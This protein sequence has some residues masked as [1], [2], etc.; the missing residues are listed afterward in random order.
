[1]ENFNATADN[2]FLVPFPCDGI[3]LCVPGKQHHQIAAPEQMP[4]ALPKIEMGRCIAGVLAVK[5]AHPVL[6]LQGWSLPHLTCDTHTPARG[7]DKHGFQISI[8]SD[9]LKVVVHQVCLPKES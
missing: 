8:L 5:A 3:G 7:I 4:A 1:M 9:S 2:Q 6:H